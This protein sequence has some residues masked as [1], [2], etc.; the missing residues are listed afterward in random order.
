MLGSPQTCRPS[1]GYWRAMSQE[2]A[3]PDLV[4]RVRFML[5]DAAV[6]PIYERR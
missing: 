5:R 2:P 1:A 4:A 3:T 6:A